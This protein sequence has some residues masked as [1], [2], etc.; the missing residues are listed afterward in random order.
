MARWRSLGRRKFGIAF[1]GLSV[2][3]SSGFWF[4]IIVLLG[5]IFAREAFKGLPSMS[6]ATIVKRF[7]LTFFSSAP[8]SN[9][10]DTFGRVC[11]DACAACLLLV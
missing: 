11:G 3:F 10:F 1:L 2:T 7:F 8:L 9:R 5:R 6:Y 4:T